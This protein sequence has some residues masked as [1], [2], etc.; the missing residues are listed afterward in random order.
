MA[1]SISLDSNLPLVQRLFKALQ[2]MGGNPQP[3]LEQIAFLGET[4]TRARFR[5]QTGPDGTRWK[6]SQ[7]VLE[8]GGK[9]LTK[10]GHLGDSITSSATKREA[11][12]GT[13]RIYAAIHQFGGKIDIPARSQQAYFRQD[14]KSGLVGNRFVKKRRS[15]FAQWVTIGAYSIQMPERPFLGLS[16]DDEQDILDLVSNF[17]SNLVRQKAPGGA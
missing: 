5:S 14:G 9:T 3:L 12:W 1:V 11:R 8:H 10:D 15:N 17:L 7:R 6:P 2:Q 4:S 13:N 16:T